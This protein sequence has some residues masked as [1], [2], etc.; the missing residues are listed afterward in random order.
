MKL[1]KLIGESIGDFLDTIFPFEKDETKPFGVY[2]EPDAVNRLVIASYVLMFTMFNLGTTLTMG[3]AEGLLF[4]TGLNANRFAVVVFLF[5]FGYF[6]YKDRIYESAYR[7]CYE[8]DLVDRENEEVLNKVDPKRNEEALNVVEDVCDDAVNQIE[9][10]KTIQT[11][12]EVR[13]R[14]KNFFKGEDY[15]R[16]H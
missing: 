2:L 9:E 16:Q 10:P 8:M 11:V 13:R 4:P 1:T 7:T 3:N 12:E 15:V 5:S 6:K 14:L